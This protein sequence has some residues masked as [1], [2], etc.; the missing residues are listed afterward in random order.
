MTPNNQQE[1]AMH[2]DWGEGPWN[3]EPDHAV[4]VDEATGLDCMIR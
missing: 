3:N 2:E 4:W 1:R